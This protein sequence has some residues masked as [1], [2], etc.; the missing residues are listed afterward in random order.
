MTFGVLL[1]VWSKT[2]LHQ[3]AA[4]RTVPGA[5]VGEHNELATLGILRASRLKITGLS[6]EPTSNGHLRQRSTA[7]RLLRV[8][9]VMRSEAVCDV[10]SHR[11]VRCTT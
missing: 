2:Y 3:P 11:T 4:H 9:N 5:Q 8:Q 10:R 1:Q 6:D 7:T